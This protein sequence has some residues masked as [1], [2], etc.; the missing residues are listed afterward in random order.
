MLSQTFAHS[1][2]MGGLSAA[3]ND[4][5]HLNILN[6]A[7]LAHLEAT[8]FEVGAFARYANLDNQAKFYQY[9]EWESQL[10]GLGLHAK[11][12]G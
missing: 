8:A 12:S 2:A 7:S 1:T 9:L 4:P 3:Y 10:S 6:P 11:K 5:F